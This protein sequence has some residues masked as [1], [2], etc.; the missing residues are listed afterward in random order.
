[1]PNHSETRQLP[2]TAKQMYD[3]VADVAKYPDFIPWTIATRVKSVEPV[4]DHAVMHADMVVGFRMFREKFLSR[5]ALWEAEGK[6]DTEYV[7]GPFKYL[8]SNWEFTDTET[9]CDV[10]FKVDFEFKNR[11]LQGAAGLFFMDAMQRIVRAFEKRADALYGS[12]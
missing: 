8:I 2:Y 7:D 1:M 11:L 9:G 10:H 6:I 5:V 3:L 4:D 12:V